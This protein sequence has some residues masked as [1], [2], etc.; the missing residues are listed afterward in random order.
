MIS[1]WLFTF[2]GKNTNI[3]REKDQYFCR[4][5]KKFYF[6][7]QFKADNKILFDHFVGQCV[8]ERNIVGELEG[9]ARALY[10]H[11]NMF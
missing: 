4:I 7:C 6:F 8:P 5:T 10:P 11:K 1:Y 3:G 2:A 9:L